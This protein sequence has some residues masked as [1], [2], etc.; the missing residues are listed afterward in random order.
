[1]TVR[2]RRFQIPEKAFSK[3]THYLFRYPAK[4]HPPVVRKLI[5]DYTSEGNTLLDPFCGSGTL[6]VE[7]ALL[8]RNSLGSDIDPVAVF[9]SRVKTQRVKVKALERTWETLRKRL[10]LWCRRD[11]EYERRQHDDI[12]YATVQTVARQQELW[13]PDVPNITHWFRNYVLVDLARILGEIESIQAPTSHVMFFTLCFGS[14]IRNASNAD[15]VPVSGLEVTSYMKKKE[16]AGRIVNPFALFE[17][18]VKRNIGAVREF[19]EL[20]SSNYFSR[21]YQVDATELSNRIKTPVD[22][23]ITSPPYHSAV[24][25][26]RRHTLE[27]Y[28]LGLTWDH[29]ERLGL[30]PKY[31]GRSRVPKSHEFVQDGEMLSTSVRSWERKLRNVD[32]ERADAFKH[33][34][35]A[36]R[37]VLEQL[38]ILLAKGKP[39]V[40]VLGKSR[41]E[42]E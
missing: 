10:A 40:F 32:S 33:Y 23:V 19:C 11:C 15:P 27:M 16:K 37:N 3:V 14:I 28:W 34:T 1:M 12:K 30:L 22:A 7:A 39:A 17:K 26:Y 21:F 4:F 2:L 20:S 41:W 42:N 5:K 24:D 36:M 31:I 35:V 38:S 9:V 29:E 18:A 13:I 8:N 6:A 25:Y